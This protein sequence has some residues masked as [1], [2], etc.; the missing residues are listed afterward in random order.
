MGWELDRDMKTFYEM[1]QILES[2]H[3]EYSQVYE[4]WELAD[5]HPWGGKIEV[6]FNT[7]TYDLPSYGG[8]SLGSHSGPAQA[9]YIMPVAWRFVGKLV[10][11]KEDSEG[12]WETDEKHNMIVE[13]EFANPGPH[14]EN[15][16]EPYKSGAPGTTGI[17]EVI[18]SVFRAIMRDIDVPRGEKK[19]DLSDIE[20]GPMKM[21][22]YKD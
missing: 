22:T 13:R 2:R 5:Y 14:G 17:A 21:D 7:E 6:G 10:K 19:F 4:I 20:G 11:Y 9:N 16:P 12:N 1:L 18:N 3:Y 8:M 15:I